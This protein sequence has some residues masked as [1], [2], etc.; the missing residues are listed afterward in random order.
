MSKSVKKRVQKAKP[1]VKKYVDANGK[2]RV[3]HT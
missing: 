2:K 3:C 1:M